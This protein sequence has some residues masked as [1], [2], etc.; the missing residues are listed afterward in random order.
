[1]FSHVH[2]RSFVHVITCQFIHFKL[3]L[4]PTLAPHQ[5]RREFPSIYRIYFSYRNHNL[6]RIRSHGGPEEEDKVVFSQS[7]ASRDLF[8]HPFGDRIRIGHSQEHVTC[9]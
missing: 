2:S 1:M 9:K 7:R 8:D 6:S 4:S 3:P 5:D